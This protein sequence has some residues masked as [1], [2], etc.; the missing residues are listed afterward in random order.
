MK[1]RDMDKTQ[2][3]LFFLQFV[4]VVVLVVLLGCYSATESVQKVESTKSERSKQRARSKK[5]K[6]GD[7]PNFTS[8]QLGSGLYAF[9]YEGHLYFWELDGFILHVASCPAVHTTLVG[10]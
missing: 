9:T 10:P 5:L 2:R 8:W 1:V 4:P 6:E 7:R 3:V